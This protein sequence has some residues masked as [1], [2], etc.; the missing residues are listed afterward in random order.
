MAAFI[1]FQSRQ[2]I[3]S[4]T[5][6]PSS[7]GIIKAIELIDEEKSSA[8]EMIYDLIKNTPLKMNKEIAE[9]IFLGIASLAAFVSV[10]VKAFS[11]NTKAITELRCSIDMLKEEIADNK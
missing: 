8:S 6:P 5:A 9:I 3:F 2:Q 4:A 10:F 1:R 7:M 11:N